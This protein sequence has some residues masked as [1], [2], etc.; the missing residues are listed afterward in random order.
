MLIE[1]CRQLLLALVADGPLLLLLLDGRLDRGVKNDRGLLSGLFN[2]LDVQGSGRI[3]FILRLHCLLDHARREYQHVL[4]LVRI[5][6][7]V[8]WSIS[9]FDIRVVLVRVLRYVAQLAVCLRPLVKLIILLNGV[10]F[11]HDFQPELILILIHNSVL[12][13]VLY[14]LALGLLL[15]RA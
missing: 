7:R 11:G 10:I 4:V 13:I 2:R 1:L 14:A 6:V 8:H 9:I 3:H 15:L 12:S 5:V